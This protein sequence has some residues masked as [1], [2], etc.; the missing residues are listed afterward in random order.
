MKSQLGQD[1]IS[2]TPSQ[3][4]QPYPYPNPSALLSEALA[5]QINSQEVHR[6]GGGYQSPWVLQEL[7][8]VGFQGEAT[9]RETSELS[10]NSFLKTSLGTNLSLTT[11]HPKTHPVS[12]TP[13]RPDPRGGQRTTYPPSL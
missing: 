7:R 13:S 10:V 8:E 3:L 5:R 2:K 12:L 6:Q 11:G 4:L 1:F 9:W